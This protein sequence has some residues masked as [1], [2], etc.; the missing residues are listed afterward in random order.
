LLSNWLRVVLDPQQR[1]RMEVG[2]LRND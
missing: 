1:W 2:G